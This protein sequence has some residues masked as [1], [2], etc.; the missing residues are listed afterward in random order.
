[1]EGRSDVDSSRVPEA[2]GSPF[3]TPLSFFP[4]VAIATSKQFGPEGEIADEL[5]FLNGIAQRRCHWQVRS[6]PRPQAFYGLTLVTIS[7]TLLPD[8]ASDITQG[9]FASTGMRAF[10]DGNLR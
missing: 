4:W 5:N 8:Q 10:W 9:V 6:N 7:R 1:M 3:E 2:I